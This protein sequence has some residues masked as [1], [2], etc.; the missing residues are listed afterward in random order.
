MTTSLDELTQFLSITA[1]K[2]FINDNTAQARRTA[3]SKLFG[4]LDDEQ[5]N[6]EYVRDNLGVVKA[7]FSNLNKDVAGATVDEYARRVKLV[8]DDFTG[9][10][11]DR[12]GWERATAAK[13][14]GRPAD[15]EKKAKPKADKPKAQG[16][17]AASTDQGQTNQDER[18]VT[19]PIRP[20]FDLK[21]TL[22][23][24]G[25]TVP[26]LKKLVYFLL[27]YAQDWEPSE[28]PRSVFNML[29]REEP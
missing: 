6:V 18:V 3:C 23:R 13:Q 21:I 12:G 25:L 4:I 8:I 5:K 15:G 1:D 11:A 28:S 20:D 17:G 24:N 10:T 29:E 2:G 26:E 16:N 19:F 27:P 7:R 14:A 9:W 22:P